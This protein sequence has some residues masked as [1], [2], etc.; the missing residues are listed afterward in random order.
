MIK[1]IQPLL[2]FQGESKQKDAD[3]FQGALRYGHDTELKIQA[4]TNVA[5]DESEDGV[6]ITL[7]ESVMPYRKITIFIPTLDNIPIQVS[8]TKLI[9]ETIQITHN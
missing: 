2:S 5:G 8:E 7:E 4:L 9:R 6:E 1:G 3:W